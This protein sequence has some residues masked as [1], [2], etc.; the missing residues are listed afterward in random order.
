MESIENQLPIRNA[1]GAIIVCKGKPNQ[2]VAVK[3]VMREDILENEKIE[4]IDI[5]KGGI[6]LGETPEQA[7]WR[8]INEEL[9]TNKIRVLKKLPFGIN[10]DFPK[11]ENAK[12]SSQKTTLFFVEYLGSP[13]DLKP[14]TSEIS[15]IFF[16]PIQT[17]KKTFTFKETS[18]AIEKFLKMKK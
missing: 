6:K 8:E 11:K 18:E 9:G 1:V 2:I 14:K 7:I 5:P 4:E 17:T 10:F 12:Y 16:T 15:E 3:K 13:S